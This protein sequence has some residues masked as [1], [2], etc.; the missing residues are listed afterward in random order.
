MHPRASARTLLPEIAPHPVSI[1]FSSLGQPR[2]T[3]SRPGSLNDVSTVSLCVR[4][5]I[6]WEKR[7]EQETCGLGG[8]WTVWLF[9]GCPIHTRQM[10]P[11]NEGTIPNYIRGTTA[12]GFVECFACLVSTINRWPPTRFVEWARN[13]ASATFGTSSRDG[14]ACSHVQADKTRRRSSIDNHYGAVTHPKYSPPTPMPHPHAPSL[15]NLRMG[16]SEGI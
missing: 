15:T 10:I 11:G 5:S 9:T 6:Q 4:H 14:P 3:A 8:S 2:A 13:E 16:A 1:N 12:R 7:A